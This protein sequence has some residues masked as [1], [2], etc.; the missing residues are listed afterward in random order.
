[1]INII[2]IAS[3]SLTSI[4]NISK[5]ISFNQKNFLSR[6][7]VLFLCSLL[8]IFRSFLLECLSSFL[9]S[10]SKIVVSWLI[11][12]QLMLMFHLLDNDICCVIFHSSQ[13]WFWFCWISNLIIVNDF[14][15]V[16]EILSSIS[17]IIRWVF[18]SWY[19]I[20]QLIV[21]ITIIQN[22]LYF[23]FFFLIYDDRR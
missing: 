8:D 10:D 15:C 14:S 19:S 17:C 16:I 7:K 5:H 11:L 1:M 3:K 18:N 21:V 13:C 20:L 22:V 9:L 4:E 23:V 2:S 6:K 12:F